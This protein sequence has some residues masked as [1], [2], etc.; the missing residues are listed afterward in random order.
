MISPTMPV[1]HGCC[2]RLE[3]YVITIL[4]WKA[5]SVS[6][7]SAKSSWTEFLCFY[8]NGAHM[9]PP[10]HKISLSFFVPVLV[11]IFGQAVPRTALIQHGSRKWPVK[12]AEGDDGNVQLK[13]PLPS[14]ACRDFPLTALYASRQI[15]VV[16]TH[17]SFHKEVSHLRHSDP[18]EIFCVSDQTKNHLQYSMFLNYESTAH[19]WKKKCAYVGGQTKVGVSKNACKFIKTNLLSINC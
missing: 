7:I 5:I 19:V 9:I 8:R 16:E 17:P 10:N 15:I 3:S 2:C 14:W 1:F 11:H 12:V 6:S 13:E 4:D 18:W